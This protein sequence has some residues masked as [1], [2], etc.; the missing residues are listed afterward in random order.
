MK[1]LGSEQT[2]RLALAWPRPGW[3][4]AQGT[5]A[6]HKTPHWLLACGRDKQVMTEYIESSAVHLT[7]YGIT[8]TVTTEE[9]AP[10]ESFGLEAKCRG[11]WL[12]RAA[13]LA[14]TRHAARGWLGK[15]P[16]WAGPGGPG[17]VWHHHACP[18]GRWEMP[19]QTSRRIAGAGCHW[20]YSRAA[21]GA[22]RRFCPGLNRGE[23]DG[24]QG[25]NGND[26]LHYTK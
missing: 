10:G 13:L 16:R 19:A 21:R 12:R 5:G 18:M 4:G 20:G 2:A 8:Y 17:P 26:D 3:T 1:A 11:S 23:D 22:G 24:P 14:C 25:G 9:A 6:H 7:L 15:G